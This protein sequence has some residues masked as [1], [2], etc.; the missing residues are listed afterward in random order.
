MNPYTDLFGDSTPPPSY[1]PAPSVFDRQRAHKAKIQARI[2]RHVLPPLSKSIGQFTPPESGSVY[3]GQ[4][5]Y[6][7]PNYIVSIPEYCYFNRSTGEIDSTKP[8]YKSEAFK[9]NQKNL[10]QN[11][12]KG[13]LSRKAVSGLRNAI[14]WLC[15]ASQ[16]KR[17]FIKKTKT[18]FSFK[19]NFVTLTLPDTMEKISSTILQKKLLNPFLVY[20]RKYHELKNYVWR[21]EFQA[22]GKLHVHIVTD[23]FIHHKIVRDQWNSQLTKHGFMAE[24]KAKHGHSNPNSTDIHPTKS[25]KNLAGYCAKYMS[26]KNA[27]FKISQAP[28]HSHEK[29]PLRKGWYLQRLNFWNSPLNPKPITGRIWSCNYELSQANKCMVNIPPNDCA[30]QMETLMNKEIRYKTLFS[31]ISEKVKAVTPAGSLALLPKKVGEIFFIKAKQ[32]HLNI[33]GIIKNTF[34]DTRLN[35]ASLARQFTVFELD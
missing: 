12:R 8:Q 27:E 22:N 30:Q 15:L 20:M 31:V 17:V 7:K 1:T 28:G 34:E 9:A 21:L 16:P 33:T 13:K 5:I 35:V 24:F 32:W 11:E 29:A 19:V 14:N 4:S 3:A 26:K 25:I 10:E 18:S 6:I 2:D 23:T